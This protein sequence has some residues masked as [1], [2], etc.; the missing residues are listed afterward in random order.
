MKLSKKLLIIGLIALPFFLTE[1]KNITKTST[2]ITIASESN[3]SYEGDIYKDFRPCS[4][5]YLR[6]M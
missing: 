6:L 5:N 3:S 1:S 2:T 4:I